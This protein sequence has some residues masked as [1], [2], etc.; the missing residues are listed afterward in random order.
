LHLKSGVNNPAH[1][2]YIRV[3][4]LALRVLRLKPDPPPCALVEM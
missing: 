3:A 2:D 4:Q 1:A